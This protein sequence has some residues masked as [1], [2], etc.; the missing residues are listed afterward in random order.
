[1]VS[2]MPVNFAS[3]DVD[4]CLICYFEGKSLLGNLQDSAVFL[5]ELLRSP[6]TVSDILVI[7]PSV[8]VV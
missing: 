1:M 8:E 3:I 4:S 6:H 7:F 2:A 5:F